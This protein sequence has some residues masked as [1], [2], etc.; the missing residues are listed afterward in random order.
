MGTEWYEWRFKCWD[1]RYLP[2]TG[3]TMDEALANAGLA[4]G[5]VRRALPIKYHADK[6][7][8]PEEVKQRLRELAKTPEHKARKKLKRRIRR[9]YGC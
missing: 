1:G 3:N 7:T 4:A 8:M 9:A 5:D 6:K 2:S